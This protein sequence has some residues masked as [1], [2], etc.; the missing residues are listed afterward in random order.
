[1]DAT[2][3]L[4]APAEA[5][6]GLENGKVVIL[7]QGG[8]ALT[9]AEQRLLDPALLGSA[10]NISLSPE[11][12]LKH[13]S[14]PA[15]DR[16]AL[17]AMMA[18]YAAFARD[19]VDTIAPAYRPHLV[20][21]R[22]SFRPAE[23]A[24]RKSSPVRDD[25]R[26]HVDA[27]PA[28]PMGGRRILRVFANVNPRQPRQWNVGEPFEAVARRFLPA[29]KAKPAP[30]RA[31]MAGLGITKRYR[32]LYDEY[33][34]GLHDG[35]KLDLA[36]QERCEKTPVAFQPGTVWLCYTDQVMHAALSGQHAL[37]QTFYLP[38]AA[39]ADP[40]TTPLAV[41]ERMTGARLV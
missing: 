19:L 15:P 31:L 1:M 22:T 12:R 41:L 30:L 29:I 40:A 28:T 2:L 13:T 27:F 25:S 7:P 37:E 36:Y 11:G 38:P 9:P 14:A 20:R 24:G 35:A 4:N 10:K 5:I 8:F 17:T 3:L 18:R 39:M 32:S 6:G 16:P 33:M 23:I 21:G 26:L 34:L